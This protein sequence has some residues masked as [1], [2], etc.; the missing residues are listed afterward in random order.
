MEFKKDLEFLSNFYFS[1]IL[2]RGV[3]WPTVEHA[4]QATKVKDLSMDE[5]IRNLNH[6]GQAKKVGRRVEIRKDWESIKVDVMT[7]L[8]LLK[9]TQ[10]KD[11]KKK[12]TETNNVHL[13]EGNYWHDNFWGDCYCIKCKR[14]PGKNILGII[15]ME[16][17]SFLRE[18]NDG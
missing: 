18:I 15:L 1:R 3:F 14:V 8:V 12:L 16:V 9:F 13:V 11:L 7:D 17:R 6:P 4:F 2:Y 10:N 5:Y